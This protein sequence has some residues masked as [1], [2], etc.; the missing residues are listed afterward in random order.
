MA[1]GREPQDHQAK[2]RLWD[3]VVPAAS[4]DRDPIYQSSQRAI[5][6]QDHHAATGGEQPNQVH[7][8]AQQQRYNEETEY[9]DCTDQKPKKNACVIIW[10]SKTKSSEQASSGSRR[11][12]SRLQARY[13]V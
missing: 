2:D 11:R 10:L 9:T 4:I 1:G 13:P 5:V 8:A 12:T 7:P 3:V 6:G